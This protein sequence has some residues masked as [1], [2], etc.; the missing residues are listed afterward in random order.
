[1]ITMFD[2]KMILLR[3]KA[4]GYDFPKPHRA[5][6][7]PLIPSVYFT[8]FVKGGARFV[9]TH[10]LLMMTNVCCLLH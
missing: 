10:C 5:R 1:L 6:I 7:V 3:R 4:F 2:A 8:D 9:S